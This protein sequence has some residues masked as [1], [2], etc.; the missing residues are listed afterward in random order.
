MYNIKRSLA[1][2]CNGSTTDSDSVCWGSNPYSA[3]KNK[4]H[5][6]S[7]SLFF[8]MGFEQGGNRL[9]LRKKTVRW[10]VFA[11][12]GNEQSEAK[13]TGRRHTLKDSKKIKRKMHH[14]FFRGL[15][16]LRNLHFSLPVEQE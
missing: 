3:A 1:E 15:Y 5:D 7:W 11:D 4:D 16:F 13:A 8:S 2:L 6:F 14:D 9:S 12:V 10:T